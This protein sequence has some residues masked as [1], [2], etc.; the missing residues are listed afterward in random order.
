MIVDDLYQNLFGKNHI[1]DGDVIEMAEHGRV[2]GVSNG[3]PF[4]MTSNAPMA[5]KVTESGTT[6]YVARSKPGTLEAT[7]LWQCMK[8][9]ESSGAVITWADGDDTYDNIA[10]NLAGLTYS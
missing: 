5:I 1:T 8:I 9:D 10:T 7:A 6:T 4:K 3:Q 2:G